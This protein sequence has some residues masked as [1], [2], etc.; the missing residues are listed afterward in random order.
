MKLS[1]NSLVTEPAKKRNSD[2]NGERKRGRPRADTNASI[3][4]ARLLSVAFSM[5]A[6][7]GYEASTMR[8]MARELDVSHNLLNVRFGRKSNLWKAAVDWRLAEAAREVERA[9]T[10]SEEP[11]ARLRDLV[12]RFCHWAIINS[13]I[14]AI[15]YQEGQRDSWRLDYLIEQFILPFQLRLQRLIAEVA[16]E[17]QLT[18]IG[19]GALLALLVH[20]VGSYFALRPLQEKLLPD[21]TEVEG[22]SNDREADVMAEFLLKG[23]FAG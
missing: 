2:R 23:L 18:P 15:S 8:A 4:E 3:D 9:F 12:H 7:H 1:E 20:G 22:L 5:F 10:E 21:Q 17:R 14:V 11:E 13:D 16:L 6:A 19:S